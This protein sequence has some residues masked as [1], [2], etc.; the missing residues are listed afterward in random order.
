MYNQTVWGRSRVSAANYEGLF[1]QF[2]VLAA[3]ERRGSSSRCEQPLIPPVRDHRLF[4]IWI[5]S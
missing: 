5:R 3:A 4:K 2:T 1:M